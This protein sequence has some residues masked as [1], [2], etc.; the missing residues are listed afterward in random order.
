MGYLEGGVCTRSVREMYWEFYVVFIDG[1]TIW[2]RDKKMKCHHPISAQG[3]RKNRLKANRSEDFAT[4][5]RKIVIT[6][7]PNLS[8]I[9]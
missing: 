3:T 2:W 4:R 6:A 1:F 5:K 7:Y 8:S 9:V